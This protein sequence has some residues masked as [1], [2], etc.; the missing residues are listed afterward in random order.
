M[1]QIADFR[2]KQASEII[3]KRD[4]LLTL[5]DSILLK[6]KVKDSLISI[7][8]EERKIVDVE[9]SKKKHFYKK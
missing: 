1:N 6:K 4:E 5:N 8:L 3:L 7:Q 2:K 9:K